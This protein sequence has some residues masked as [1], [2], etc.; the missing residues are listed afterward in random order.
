M[1]TV[2]AGRESVNQIGAKYGN[3]KMGQAAGDSVET[4]ADGGD[5]QFENPDG[6]RAQDEGDDRAGNAVRNGPAY[7]NDDHGAGGERGRFE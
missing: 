7:E 6:E 3:V 2:M 4:R 1:A 5:R